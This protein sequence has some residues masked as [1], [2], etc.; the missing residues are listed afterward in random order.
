M[1]EQ[2]EKQYKLSRYNEH[3][4]RD[5]DTYLWNTLSGAFIRL[6]EDA[7]LYIEHF[8]GEFDNSKYFETLLENGCIV[9]GGLDELGMVL[10]DEKMT[11]LNRDVEAV[12]YTIAPGLACNYNCPYCFEKNRMSYAS[13]SPEV[14][15]EVCD[16]IIRASD[17]KN[18]L[19]Y[20]GITWFGGEPLLY[21]DTIRNISS[22][23]MTYCENRGIGYGAGIVTN[24]RYLTVANARML[25]SVKVKYVQMAVDGMRDFYA[26]S[27]GASTSD[28][29]AVTDNITA[30]ADILP[31]TVRINVA[32]DIT[33]AN[34]VTEY[35]LNERK[36]DGKIKIYIAHIRDYCDGNMDRQ[37]LSHRKFLDLE[38]S[39]F[40]MF[41]GDQKKYRLESL[42][43]ISPKRRC[44]TCL[45][46]SGDNFCIGPEGEL[47][48]CEHYFGNPD[49][50]VGTVRDGEFFN[51][52]EMTYLK[53]THPVECEAC[54][55]F[56]ICMGGCMNDAKN[57][58]PALSCDSFR[59]RLIDYKTLSEWKK[60]Q[61]RP[62]LQNS[63]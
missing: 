29:D 8:N 55:M 7:I 5:G 62:E 18:R 16:F 21:P 4:Q 43:W 1:L 45:S 22:R 44:T 32:D 2:H 39:Y 52:A 31:I 50:I 60:H 24:G 37:K 38:K 47:Y 56:P 41:Q 9:S 36:L 23:I 30:T 13:M 19:K 48:R 53:H 40:S 61:M 51:D 49:K 25:R 27:K 42:S 54:R 59:E 35:L 15:E 10:M 58:S 12:H 20:I 57:G 11:M 26:K 28:F 34:R 63:E 33:D 14:Q 3:F 17:K 46:V 6:Q